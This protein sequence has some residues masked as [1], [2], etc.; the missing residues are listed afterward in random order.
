VLFELLRA[1]GYALPN[2]S[3]DSGKEE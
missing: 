3:L 2:V 1:A